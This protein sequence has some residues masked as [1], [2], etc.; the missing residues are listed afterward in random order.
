MPGVLP[1]LTPSPVTCA[2]WGRGWS[3]SGQPPRLLIWPRPVHR[4]RPG[5]EAV[6]ARV[7]APA[8]PTEPAGAVVDIL[9]SRVADDPDW[10]PQVT[11]LRDISTGRGW[12]T[13]GRCQ[14]WLTP[15]SG[16]C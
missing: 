2:G 1:R 4:G 7:G 11:A 6:L 10:G 5:C 15:R 12:S 3:G 14:T 16:A 13:G 9:H 8:G